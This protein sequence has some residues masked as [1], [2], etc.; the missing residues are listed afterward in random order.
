MGTL[1]WRHAP[2]RVWG[3]SVY[4]E[5]PEPVEAAALRKAAA[6]VIVGKSVFTI[7]R[8]WNEDPRLHTVRGN[9]WNGLVIAK[10]LQRRTNEQGTTPLLDHRTFQSVV[11]A[12]AV[13]RQS[14]QAAGRSTRTSKVG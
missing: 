1:S 3:W 11:A 9:P 2:R 13:P 12:L 14:R 7:A 8:E 10:M 4:L 6:D 5:M